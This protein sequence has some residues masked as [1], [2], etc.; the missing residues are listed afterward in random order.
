[1]TPKYLAELIEIYGEIAPDPSLNQIDFNNLPDFIPDDLVFIYKNYGRT[2]IRNNLQICFPQDFS[3]IAKIIFANDEDLNPDDLFFYCYSS[4]GRLYFLHKNWGQGRISLYS[5][6]I[7]LLDYIDQD[8]HDVIDNGEIYDPFM[9]D[10]EMRDYFD[11][12]N[13]PLLERA[14]RKLGPVEIGECYGFVP[15]LSMGGEESLDC[16]RRLKALEHFAIVAQTMR[17]DI[18]QIED[19]GESSVFRPVGK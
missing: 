18:I 6:S 9:Y 3:A 13:E 15:A 4:F 8:K 10:D 17:Y 5:G 1:M 7:S 16:L 2:F 12:E 14:E 19:N 11:H